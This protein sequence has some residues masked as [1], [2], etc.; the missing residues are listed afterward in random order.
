MQLPRK[1]IMPAEW[2]EH[3]AVWLGWEKDSLLDYYPIIVN[4]IKAL[5]N[6]VQ[7]KI[8]F[9]DDAL[10][11]GAKAYLEERGI[12]STMYQSYIMPGDRFWIR[13][14]GA[15][16]LVNKKGALAVANFSWDSYGLP[17]L[18]RQ[19]YGANM[20]SVNRFL[21]RRKD[22]MQKTGKVDSLMA[23]AEKASLLKTDVVHEGGAMEVNGKGTLILCEATT[24]QRNP[25]MRKDY[26]ESEF[27]R[28]LGV[29]KIIWMKKGLAEDPHRYFRRIAGNY[30]GGGT[31]GHTDEFVRFANS[32]TILLA[33]VDETE[34]DTNP[35]NQMNYERMS[36]N[37]EI[38]KH[39]TDQDGKPFTIIKVPLPDLIVKKIVARQKIDQQQKTFDLSVSSFIPAEAP[40]DGDSLLR[41]PASSYLN[42]FV[43]NGLVLLPAYTQA[44]SSKEKEEQV[45]KIFEQHFPGR[46]LVFID[47]MA[48]NWEG[49]GIHC[50]T[51]QQPKRK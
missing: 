4:I 37:L 42:Y 7:V 50:S 48:L 45:R 32:N 13:D 15:T 14:H 6:N 22:M 40:K 34:K 24:L 2:E 47:A 8:A 26:I 36:E 44:G 1:Y 18:L 5:S 51:Q 29:T 21:D 41:V 9:H 43:T 33:W 11:T 31:G 12:D 3:D 25:G 20:D 39:S 27:K 38:L 30:V 28:L 46:K 16:F 23:V 17:G 35:I 10:M 19:V 49:G